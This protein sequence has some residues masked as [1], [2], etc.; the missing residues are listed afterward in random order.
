VTLAGPPEFKTRFA[1]LIGL[2]R[3]Y[4]VTDIGFS[5]VPIGSQYQALQGG[6][7]QLAVAFTTDGQLSQ[8]GYALLKDPQ[9]IFGFQNVTFVVRRDVLT[10]E[11]PA[12][13]QTINAV[14]AKLSTQALRV[15]NAAVVLDQQNPAAVAR[16]FLGANGLA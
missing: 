13:A 9:N 4:G 2:R 1:G 11:G 15:M 8:G 6:R 5:P 10:R 12:F 16:Q 14:S 7:A 3:V